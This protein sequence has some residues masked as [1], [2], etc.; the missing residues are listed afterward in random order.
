MM[1]MMMQQQIIGKSETNC[2][3]NYAHVQTHIQLI[4]ADKQLSSLLL[5]L[6]VIVSLIQSHSW[7]VHVPEKESLGTAAAGRLLTS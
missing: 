2:K 5:E 6:L 3:T 7:L 1:M 4:T